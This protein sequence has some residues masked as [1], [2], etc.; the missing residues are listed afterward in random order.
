MLKVNIVEAFLLVVFSFG[1][2]EVSFYA[3]PPLFCRGHQSSQ[4]L[5]IDNLTL[6]VEHKSSCHAVVSSQEL[7]ENVIGTEMGN[8][9]N[10]FVQIVKHIC[11]NL[12][13]L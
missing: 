13:E 2:P 3:T 5:T 10:A 8:M 11:P 12:S 6:N 1:Y 4:P 7:W 9:K